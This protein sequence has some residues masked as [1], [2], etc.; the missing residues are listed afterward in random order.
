MSAPPDPA[1]Q[2]RIDRMQQILGRLPRLTRQV[3]LAHRL[4]D[5]TYDDIARRTGLTVRQVEWHI[6]CAL[7]ALMRGVDHAPRPRWKFW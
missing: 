7:L 2:Q 6:A 5:M 3:F 4:E 1:K